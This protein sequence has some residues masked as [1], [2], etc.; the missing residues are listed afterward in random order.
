[1]L[2]TFSSMTTRSLRFSLG[3]PEA[4]PE[5]EPAAPSGDVGMECFG[6][7]WVAVLSKLLDSGDATGEGPEGDGLDAHCG[8]DFIS[9]SAPP[10]PLVFILISCGASLSFLCLSCAT[11]SFAMA[12]A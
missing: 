11:D 7:L 8:L 12:S 4:V 6:G 10:L 2:L 9:I 1:M 3:W 5:P